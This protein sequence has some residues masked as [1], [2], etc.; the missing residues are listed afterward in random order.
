MV[1]IVLL[2]GVFGAAVIF[3]REFQRHLTSLAGPWIHKH[4]STER[5]QAR[6]P[7]NREL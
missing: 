6:L 2:I 5:S 1:C 7:Q 3:T 4:N